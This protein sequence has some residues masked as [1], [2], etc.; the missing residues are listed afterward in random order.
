M[1]SSAN[2]QILKVKVLKI[3]KL[4]GGWNK[5]GNTGKYFKKWQ[6]EGMKIFYFVEIHFAFCLY[7]QDSLGILNQMLN[8]WSKF[9]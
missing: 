6:A 1:N 9:Q 5:R 4:E 3:D 2:V 8:L 7:L